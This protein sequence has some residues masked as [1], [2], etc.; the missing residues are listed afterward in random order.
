MTPFLSRLLL[1]FL[2][3]LPAVAQQDEID[4]SPVNIPADSLGAFVPNRKPNLDV[5]RTSGPITIDG[6]LGDPGWRNA[7]HGDNFAESYPGDATRPPVET[8]AFITYDEENLYVGFICHDDPNAIRATM[9]DRDE[10]W[11]EDMVGIML[12]TYGDGSRA[13]EIFTNALGVQGDVLWTTDDE[14]TGFDMVFRS[15][16]RITSEGYVVEM[17]IP[18]RSLRFPDRAV[19]PWKATFWRIHPRASRQEYTWAA[20]NQDDPCQFCQFGTLSGIE[21][22]HAGGPL[23]LLPAVV[24]VQSGELADGRNPDSEFRNSRPELDAGIGLRCSITPSITAEATINPDFSQIESDAAQIDVNTTFALSFPERRPFFQEGSDLFDTWLPIVYSRSINNPIAA[25][26]LTGRLGNTS[27]AYLGAYDEETPIFLPFEESSGFA[28]A[29]EGT[30]GIESYSSLFRV[31]QSLDDGSHV[32][33]LVTDRRLTGGG[34]G[35]VAAV[36]GQLRFLGN[37]QIEGQISASHT[38]EPDDSTM[39]RSLA[40][41]LFDGGRHTATYDGED[42]TG[43]GIYLSLER[44]SRTWSFDADYWEKSP[45]YR[46]MNGVVTQNDR[47]ELFIYGEYT[48]YPETPIIVRF[49]PSISAGRFWNYSWRRKDEFIRPQLGFN[50]TGQTWLEVAW[51]ASRETFRDVY[52][53]GIRRVEIEFNTNASNVVSGGISYSGGRFVARTTQ[54]PVL[55]RGMQL[56]VNATIKPLAQLSIQPS[57]DYQTLDHPD[58]RENIFD[59]WVARVRMSYQFTRELSLR[60]VVQY[61][62]DDRALSIEPLATYKINPFTIFYAGSTHALEQFVPGESYRQTARQFFVKAQ[63]LWQI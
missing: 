29:S 13:Y 44:H 33:L 52:F 31:K 45:T 42:Y 47:R 27:F 9:H 58:T 5:R 57:I 48:F 18:F 16:S 49:T 61:V 38:A 3:A 6:D 40:G 25:A 39:T 7:A 23:S 55:G 54:V 11:N 32:G 62:D 60:L 12:D 22:V 43:H 15:E 1:L 35:S 20:M 4:R 8:E 53:P 34:S 56:E 41:K 17:A 28:H 30:D 19:Q 10:G 37:Y 14:D 46:T 24:G 63:Y 2:L 36:D 51:L 26:K 59:E 50:L 21:N